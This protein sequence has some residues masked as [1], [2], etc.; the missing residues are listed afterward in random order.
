[1]RAPT[2][3]WTGMVNQNQDCISDFTVVT[4]SVP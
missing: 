2:A 4:Y 3:V 1:M